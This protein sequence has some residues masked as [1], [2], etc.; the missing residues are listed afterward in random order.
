MRAAKITKITNNTF[1]PDSMDFEEWSTEA[2]DNNKILRKLSYSNYD[3]TKGLDEAYVVYYDRITMYNNNK[4]EE[5]YKHLGLHK[6]EGDYSHCAFYPHGGE[7]RGGTIWSAVEP[8]EDYTI[9]KLK[10]IELSRASIII[11]ALERMEV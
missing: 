11:N 4:D 8:H 2:F 9:E 7:D 5:P 3:S 10:E 6:V 1:S